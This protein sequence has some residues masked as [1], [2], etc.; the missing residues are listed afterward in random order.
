MARGYVKWM[1]KLE[2]R[3]VPEVKVH[4]EYLCF[5]SDIR[6]YPSLIT[7]IADVLEIGPG[8]NILEQEEYCDGTWYEPVEVAFI[9]AS[10]PLRRDWLSLNEE[11]FISPEVYECC[12]WMDDNL[13]QIRHLREA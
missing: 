9:W 13:H 10:H 11:G 8:G 5:P 7:T 6:H 3:E 2:G 4:K 12:Q 1:C